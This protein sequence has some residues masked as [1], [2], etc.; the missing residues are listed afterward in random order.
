MTADAKIPS[1]PRIHAFTDDALGE[2]DAVALAELVRTGAVG[3]EELAAAAAARAEQVEELAAVAYPSYSRPLSPSARSGTFYGVPTFVKDNTDVAGMPT[4][5]GTAAFHATRAREHG[6]Y[7]RQLLSTGVTV[8]GK[9]AMPEFG[10]N[11]STEPPHARPTRNPWHPGYS[12]GG[13]SGG[14]AALVAAGV[15]PIAHGNDGGGSIRIPA[16]CAGLVGL[17]P[18]R[19]RHVDSGMARALPIN[20]VSEG[21]LT[22]T[23]RD[24][25]AYIAAAERYWRNPALPPIGHVEGPA[26][27]R[28]RI[29]LVLDNLAGPVAPGPIRAAVEK[30]A[31]TLESSGHSVEP[32]PLP[33]DARLETDFLHYW[34]LLAAVI[35][36]TGRFLDRRFD[37]GRVDDLT[38]GLRELFVRRA[39]RTPLTLYRLRAAAGIYQRALGPFDAVLLPVLG[40]TTP[41]LGLLS[42][43]VPFDELIDRL[44]AYVA[45]T[46]INNITGTPAI[47]IPAGL[48]AEGLPIGVQL[49]ATR[50]NERTLLELAYLVESEQPFPRLNRP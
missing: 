37:A 46:P 21:V 44:R 22:R 5:Q 43:T 31:A 9:S 34:G 3:A 14:A 42:P 45:F 8:L 12:V 29:A 13:S 4:N 7:T 26:S 33:F 35:T 40:H 39:L 11:A 27:R 19:G 24:T 48:T 17:K 47:A 36:T 10:F 38:A 23:V 2:H 15:V 32:V 20:I 25:A 1:P 41:E 50:G 18:S 28:M 6:P 49:A 16:A 30:V